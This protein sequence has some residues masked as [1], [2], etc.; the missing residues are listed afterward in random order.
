MVNGPVSTQIRTSVSVSYRIISRFPHLL[1]LSANRLLSAISA[2]PYYLP[3]IGVTL[4]S[5][6]HGLELGAGTLAATGISRMGRAFVFSILVLHA[7][8]LDAVNQV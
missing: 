8:L 1:R 7:H 5:F 3:S 4:A 2:I 6:P